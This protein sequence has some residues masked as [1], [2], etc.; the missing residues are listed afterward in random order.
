MKVARLTAAVVVLVA[1][2]GCVDD[3]RSGLPVRPPGSGG[4][5]SGQ[6]GDA[7]LLDA[8]SGDG[9]VA[10]NGLIC[11]VTDLRSPDVCPAVPARGGV[12]VTVTGTS[13]GTTSD[14]EGRFTLP[15]SGAV[16]VLDVAGDSATLERSTIPVGVNGALV[17]AP[18]I[19]VGDWADVLASLDQAVPDGGGAI[20]VYVSDGGAAATGVSFATVAGSSIAPYYDGGGPL[21][22]VQGGGTGAAGVALFVDV[23]AGTVTL[24]G[25]APDLRVVSPATVPVVADA[26]TFVR[27]SL[28]APP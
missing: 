14:A 12:S 27:T 23:P 4:P 17:H 13:D 8:P 9:G 3:D 20:V 7:R 26:V 10:L 1:G 21:T 2:G 19:G 24:D 6:G 18:V 28:A 16:A 15:V 11:V 25:V 22:W 5:G